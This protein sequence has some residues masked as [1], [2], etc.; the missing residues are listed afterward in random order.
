MRCCWSS[1]TL[2]RLGQSATQQNFGNAR[3]ARRPTRRSGH[4][5][6]RDHHRFGRWRIGRGL[7]PDADRE[8]GA[9]AREGLAAAA[10][11]QHA[12][13]RHGHA[14]RRVL[15]NEPWVD[16]ARQAD[17]PRRA[18]QPRRQDQMVR[19]GAAALRA[20]RVRGRSRS[21][22]PGLAD[23]LRRAGAVLRR[24][25]AAARRAHLRRR[26]DLQTAGSGL[27]RASMPAGAKQMLNGGSVAGHS[28]LSGGGRATST[29][30][31]RCAD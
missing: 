8:A 2:E 6:R 12:R 5:I 23:R 19:R 26:A 29:A 3:I 13:R 31:P 27:A 28:R 30:S 7:P 15:S 20:A 1:T 9:A 25:R 18:L 22:V 21:S 16:R 24:G 10:R 11:R 4:E 17:R 14:P